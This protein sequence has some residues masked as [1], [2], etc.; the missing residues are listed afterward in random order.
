MNPIIVPN[1]LFFEELCQRIRMHRSV[2]IRVAGRSMEPFLKNGKDFITLS[3]LP[4]RYRFRKGDV[5]LFLYGSQYVVHRL[6]RIHGQTLYMKGDH[7]NHWEIIHPEDVR[8]WVSCVQLANGRRVQARSLL[9]KLFAL[10][11]R[12]DRM[13]KN[14]HHKI[15]RISSL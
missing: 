7:Q 2:R 3:A 6:H 10:R 12:L 4:A 11:S 14:F 13:R 8:G 9:W 5:L 15:K 1:Q